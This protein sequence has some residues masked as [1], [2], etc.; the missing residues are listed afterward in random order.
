MKSNATGRALRALR[1]GAGLTLQT[2]S[3]AAGI[4]PSYLSR[5]ENG[6]TIP[7]DA[8]AGMVAVAIGEA[9]ADAADSVAV[10][11]AVAG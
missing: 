5:V 10:A 8:W 6:L 1:V 9:M 2:V 7:T 11:V 4:S 3:D